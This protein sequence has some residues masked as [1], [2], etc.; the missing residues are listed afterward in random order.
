MPCHASL[1]N[2]AA[3]HL[4][5]QRMLLL[6]LYA[7]ERQAELRAAFRVKRG[8][9]DSPGIAQRRQTRVAIAIAGDYS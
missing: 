2:V 4:V 7:G 6:R 5:Q 3:L 1:C 8:K 9:S